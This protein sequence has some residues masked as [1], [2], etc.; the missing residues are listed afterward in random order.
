MVCY[1]L[2]G[3]I[4]K[5]WVACETFQEFKKESYVVV[6]RSDQSDVFLSFSLLADLG[7]AVWV[8]L[9]GHLW[10]SEDEPSSL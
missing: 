10:S 8:S 9:V 7:M 2:H 3:L 4:I 6:L 5:I 1:S